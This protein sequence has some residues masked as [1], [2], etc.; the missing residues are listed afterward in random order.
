MMLISAVCI[1]FILIMLLLA[2][3]ANAGSFAKTREQWRV[4]MVQKIGVPLSERG[5]QKPADVF[6]VGPFAVEAWE[7]AGLMAEGTPPTIQR[8]AHLSGTVYH[9]SHPYMSTNRLVKAVD[10]LV[11]QIPYYSARLEKHEGGIVV[12]TL[13]RHQRE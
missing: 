10:A 7:R 12:A 13:V 9:V 1:T 5:I 6:E 2:L 3:W 8:Q 11:A 4:K